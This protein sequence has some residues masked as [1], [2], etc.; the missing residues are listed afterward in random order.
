M[1]KRAAA[2]AVVCTFVLFRWVSAQPQAQPA[3]VDSV[4][5]IPIKERKPGPAG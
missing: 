4:S 3:K 5:R 2:A 1:S